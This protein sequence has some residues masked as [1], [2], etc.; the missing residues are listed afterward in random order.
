MLIAM[1]DIVTNLSDPAI[2]LRRALIDGGFPQDV[3]TQM[4][5]DYY[6][7]MLRRTMLEL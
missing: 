4:A 3:A 7:L 1:Q 2:G 5:F 6:Q